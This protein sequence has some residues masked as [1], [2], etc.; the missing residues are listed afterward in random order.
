[1]LDRISD[2]AAQAK[3][4]MATAGAD[5][6]KRKQ[7][8]EAFYKAQ[9]AACEA[10]AGYRC[11]LYSFAGGNTYRLFRTLEIRD[12]RLAY[13]PPSGIGKFGGGVDNWMWPRHTGDFSFY[14]AYVGKDGKPAA[15]A[16]DNMPYQPRYFLKF[17]DQPLG[18]GDFV[19]VAGY[20]GRTNR[21]ALAAEFDATAS[22]AY[23]T[24]AR[25]YR[26]LIAL[27]EQAGKQDP[28]IQ[29]K[30]AATMASWNNVAKNYEGQLEGFKHIDA[31]TQ[32]QAE[33]R[34]VLA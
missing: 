30:Y 3:A 19:M 13:A 28:D 15:Y 10:E 18:A 22:W 24:A 5:A 33:E 29:V 32:K 31:A 34:A 16:K 20:P 25:Q 7:A 8:L 14:R 26:D 12:V 27:V 2:V 9:V 21:Y 11:E 1:M 4:A 17:A 23:P 6:L